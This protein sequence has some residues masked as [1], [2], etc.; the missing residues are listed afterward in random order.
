[1]TDYVSMNIGPNTRYIISTSGRPSSLRRY[2]RLLQ[3]ILKLDV[4]YIPIHTGSKEKPQIDPAHFAG[5][6]KGMPCI[7][8][9]ISRDI[10][11]SIIPYLDY[12]DDIAK[13]VQSVNTV[14]VQ[15]D[16]KLFGYN[17]DAMGFKFAIT[18]G[19]RLSQL[20]VA[21]AICYGCGGVASVVIAVLQSCNISVVLAGRNNI[22]V[23]TRAAELGVKMWNGETADLFVNATPASEH[24]LEEATNFLESLKGC[25][26]V[27]DHEMPGKYLKEYCV[28]NGI[29]HISGERM[30][31]PQMEAQWKLFLREAACSDQVDLGELLRLADN[32]EDSV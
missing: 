26:I 28:K 5:V 10:K 17:T 7:G 8:G 24:P 32:A 2:K 30:Y 9:A 27:F 31:Y 25:K 21:T 12:L 23:E 29:Y 3:D 11:H 1:M 14:I 22:N 6:L 13:D 18:E 16:G 15:K 20:P 4:A 19:L